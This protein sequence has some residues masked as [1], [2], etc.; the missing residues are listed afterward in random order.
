MF[1]LVNYWMIYNNY[2][3]LDVV[4][5]SN[6]IP[7]GTSS[8]L[9][10]M[11][12]TST[13]RVYQETSDGWQVHRGESLFHFHI[14]K[15]F[16]RSFDYLLRTHLG[17]NSLTGDMANILGTS[18]LQEGCP[19]QT[20]S[21]YSVH[22]HWKWLFVLTTIC[23]LLACMTSKNI[24]TWDEYGQINCTREHTSI[25]YYTLYWY[26]YPALRTD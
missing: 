15:L 18:C 10:S 4:L 13:F 20:G 6:S 22:I 12:T 24:C 26:V 7:S 3:I 2:V 9:P 16:Y 1:S 21:I 17:K 14:S 11:V 19:Q 8:V 25:N 5:S 23:Y